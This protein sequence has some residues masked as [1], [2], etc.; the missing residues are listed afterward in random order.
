[1]ASKTEKTPLNPL[2]VGVIRPQQTPRKGRDSDYKTDS[3]SELSW[4][5]SMEALH[6]LGMSPGQPG[7]GS[8]VHMLPTPPTS[9][10]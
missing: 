9:D 2:V 6:A 10:G 7:R 8:C 4:D 1:M 5:E 3:F